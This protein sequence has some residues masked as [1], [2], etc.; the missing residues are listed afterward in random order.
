MLLQL[1]TL[2]SDEAASRSLQ[3]AILMLL[4]SPTENSVEI[5]ANNPH[6][7]QQF[8][9]CFNEPTGRKA[10]TAFIERFQAE[11]VVLTAEEDGGDD[12]EDQQDKSLQELVAEARLSSYVVTQILQLVR[13][14][15]LGCYKEAQDLLRQTKVLIS[16]S[17]LMSWDKLSVVAML[18]I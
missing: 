2:P 5:H 1:A 6:S 13:L 3:M 8:L 14:F 12:D 17:P 10:L 15:T 7:Q 18:W 4:A 16:S 11:A 9:Q